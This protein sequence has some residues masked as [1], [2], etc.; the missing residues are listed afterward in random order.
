MEIL[1]ENLIKKISSQIKNMTEEEFIN[2]SSDLFISSKKPPLNLEN[3]LEDSKQ[4]IIFFIENIN[5]I[6]RDSQYLSINED[7][8]FYIN[9][10]LR[11]IKQILQDNLNNIK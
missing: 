5:S 8:L 6:L 1:K 9:L 2:F 3:I 11:I 10:S 4:R 7:S